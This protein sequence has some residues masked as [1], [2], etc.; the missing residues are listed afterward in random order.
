MTFLYVRERL[1]WP[2]TSL[3]RVPVAAL[4]H[5]LSAALQFCADGAVTRAQAE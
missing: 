1:T 5:L 3:E 2:L 4:G